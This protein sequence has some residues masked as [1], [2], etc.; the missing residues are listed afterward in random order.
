MAARARGCASGWKP[1]LTEAHIQEGKEMV[2][3]QKLPIRRIVELCSV[4]RTTIYKV[5]LIE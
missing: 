5:T 4:S 3:A 1:K 2:L